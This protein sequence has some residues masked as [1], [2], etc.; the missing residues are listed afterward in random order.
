LQDANATAAA[1]SP[2]TCHT[3]GVSIT[4]A[5]QPCGVVLQTPAAARQ[6]RGAAGQH[7]QRI[8]CVPSDGPSIHAAHQLSS[9][10]DGLV[11]QPISLCKQLTN[12]HA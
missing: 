10:T 9:H 3:A 6:P 11:V 8:S 2:S 1:G 5:T 7:M 12:I 4:Q